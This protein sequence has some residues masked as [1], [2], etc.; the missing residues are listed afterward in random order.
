[1]AY[2]QF[3]DEIHFGLVFERFQQLHDV[4]M[5]EPANTKTFSVKPTSCS[6]RFV[7]ADRRRY[8]CANVLP[9]VLRILIKISMYVFS[10][11]K[12]VGQLVMRSSRGKLRDPPDRFGT[13]TLFAVR[14]DGHK[15]RIPTVPS[16]VPNSPRYLQ[17]VKGHPRV[18]FPIIRFR[19]VSFRYVL[20]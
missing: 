8:E 7:N 15:F 18:V 16:P 12:A 4:G 17:N 5:S 10:G 6:V 9:K 3:H 2:S 19:A 13:R 14:V 20:F 11:F 1:M